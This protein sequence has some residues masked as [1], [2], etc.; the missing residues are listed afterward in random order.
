MTE[1]EAEALAVRLTRI[2]APDK[3][4]V[5]RR[6][7]NSCI[8]CRWRLS[9]KGFLDFHVEIIPSVNFHVVE[10]GAFF[11]LGRRSEQETPMVVTGTLVCQLQSGVVRIGGGGDERF[12]Q[13]AV[14]WMPFFR[15]GCW[16]SGCPVEATAHEKA[17]WI[18]GFTREDI[19]AWNLKI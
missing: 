6:S 14:Q 5:M 16:L 11:C 12:D 8:E 10:E 19:E 1:Q 4:K 17:E 18:Q 15:R 3:Q 9:Y 2:W 13:F 7:W